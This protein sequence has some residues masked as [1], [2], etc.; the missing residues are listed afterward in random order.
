MG[1]TFAV[2][3]SV[4]SLCQMSKKFWKVRS[5]PPFQFA[6]EPSVAVKNQNTLFR[7]NS[8]IKRLEHSI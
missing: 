7:G 4:P 6:A 1:S 3:S 2:S 5:A 8:V